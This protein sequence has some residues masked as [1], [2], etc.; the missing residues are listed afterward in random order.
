MACKWQKTA[1]SRLAFWWL[2]TLFYLNSGCWSTLFYSKSLPHH[3]LRHTFIIQ[4]LLKLL[5]ATDAKF[6]YEW[7]NYQACKTESHQEEA[8]VK[9]KQWI[10][11][12]LMMT[13]R[14]LILKSVSLM[15]VALTIRNISHTSGTDKARISSNEKYQNSSFKTDVFI[16][17]VHKR[18]AKKEKKENPW[19]DICFCKRQNTGKLNSCFGSKVLHIFNTSKWGALVIKSQHNRRS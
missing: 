3:L 15:W 9:K 11:G 17:N 7:T 1:V 2:C 16:L 14:K 19:S 12:H 5:K 18:E 6:M 13:D 10:S 8:Q 4:H